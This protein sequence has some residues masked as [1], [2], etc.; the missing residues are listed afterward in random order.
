MIDLDI[1]KLLL[2]AL[3]ALLVLGPQKLPVAARTAGAILRRIRVGWDSVRADVEHELQLEELKRMA[4]TASDKV[5]ALESVV[6]TD[7]TVGEVSAATH[8]LM[9]EL[10]GVEAAARA[11]TQQ[12]TMPTMSGSRMATTDND[13]ATTLLTTASSAPTSPTVAHTQDAHR[14]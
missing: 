11:Y 13:P 3:I 12:F 14:A 1:S 2:V 5:Q 4:K 10:A 8:Q 6:K 9:S 7:S